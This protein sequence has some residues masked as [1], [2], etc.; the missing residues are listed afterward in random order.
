MNLLKYS[1]Y[2]V[3]L[4]SCMITFGLNTVSAKTI[5]SVIYTDP[6][7]TDRNYTAN[8][9]VVHI[10]T[11][12]V[13]INGLFMLAAG[14]GLHPTMVLLHGVPG[15]E[16]NLD[17]AQ[18]VRRNGWNVLTFNYRGSW[19][20]PGNFSFAGNIE[21]AKAVLS[22]I[23]NPENQKKFN[24]NEKQIVLAGHS[25]GGW[26]VAMTAAQEKNIAGVVMFSAANMGG[27]AVI[28]PKRADTVAWMA[29]NFETLN[30][31]PEKMADEVIQNQQ[32][33][34][35]N[36]AAPGLKNTPLLVIYSNDSFAKGD[37]KFAQTVEEEGNKNL[38]LVHIPTNHGY[39]DHRIALQSTII[40][41][42][43]QLPI[44]K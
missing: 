12:N 13:K 8:D 10:P 14:K 6:V 32:K 21:D 20:S 44:L 42:L 4:S 7:V 1:F 43:D 11:Q 36:N 15:N 34:D 35:M 37:Q 33:F 22:F 29:D 27:N 38:S 3:V 30:T 39:N 40:N 2:S 26:V 16:K 28:A 19:G 24:I 17:L 18:A 5:P 23:Q 25:M 41:W 9:Q 31:T